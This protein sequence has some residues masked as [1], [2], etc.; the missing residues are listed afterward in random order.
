MRTLPAQPKE[1][2][3]SFLEQD[4]IFFGNL[5]NEEKTRKIVVI[6]TAAIN[7]IF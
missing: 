7:H 6:D 5:Q 2:T 1:N 3:G 4:G